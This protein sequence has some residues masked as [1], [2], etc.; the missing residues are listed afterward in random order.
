MLKLGIIGW[1][2]WGRNYAKYLD[3]TID[4]ALEWV[5]DVR[6]EMLNDAHKR[7]PHMHLTNDYKDLVE[8]KLDGII[9]AAPA[10]L[11]FPLAKY[12]I[13][14][15]INLLIEK[16]LTHSLK[17]ALELQNLLYKNQVKILIGH[18]FLYNQSV[19]WLKEKIDKKYF[20]KIFYLEFKRQSYGPIRD[21]VNVIWD[22]AAHDLAITTWLMNNTYPQKISACGKRFSR[23]K[24]EDIAVIT[25]KYPDNVL[26]NINVAWLYPVK[27]RTLTLLGEKKMAVFEDTNTV[28]PIKVYE[29]SLQYPSE[30]EPYKAGFRLGDIYIP[31]INQIDPL[32]TQIKHFVSYLKD[33]EQPL[34][35]VEDGVNIVRLLEAVDTSIRLNKEVSVNIK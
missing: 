4:A 2:Y 8:K 14:N 27:I 12:L 21:D 10:S 16:P 17:T 11:H 6:Q 31:R 33:E 20:G 24:Q 25:L 30:K 5:C 28:E 34:T 32:Y 3:T 13:E 1:G 7:Y 15:K 26:V 18:T 19:R 35:P 23:H 29:T 9:I 22:F